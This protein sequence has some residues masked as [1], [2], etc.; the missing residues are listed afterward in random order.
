MYFKKN[1][2]NQLEQVGSVLTN[3]EFAKTLKAFQAW[4]KRFLEGE[5]VTIIKTV[6]KSQ[7]NQAEILTLDLKIMKLF[8]ETHFA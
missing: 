4:S 7:D 1:N 6:N 5:T 2:L 8:G 3:Q